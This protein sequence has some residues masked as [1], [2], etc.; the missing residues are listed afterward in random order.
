[1][2]LL[3]GS[4]ENVE[5]ASRIVDTVFS[6]SANQVKHMS[7]YVVIHGVAREGVFEINELVVKKWIL[8]FPGLTL[9]EDLSL[10]L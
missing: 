8:R 9:C 2:I 5:R 10:D 4:A 1:M 6:H 3:G 7:A